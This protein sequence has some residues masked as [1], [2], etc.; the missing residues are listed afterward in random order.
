MLTGYLSTCSAVAGCQSQD[1]VQWSDDLLQH[2]RNAKSAFTNHKSITLPQ[3]DDQLWIVTD[4]SVTKQGIGS[5]I[6]IKGWEAAFGRVFQ[7]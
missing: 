2:F 7:C 3:S 1:K 5:T 6:H 4:A